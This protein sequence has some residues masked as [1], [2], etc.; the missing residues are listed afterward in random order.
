[1]KNIYTYLY[2][3]DLFL[4][5]PELSTWMITFKDKFL[6]HNNMIWDKCVKS[7]IY[8][9]TINIIGKTKIS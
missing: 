1:M 6:V 2:N 4:T 8:K 7:Q 3:E 9:K 5:Q